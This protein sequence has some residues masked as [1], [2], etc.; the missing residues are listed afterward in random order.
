M[1]SYCSHSNLSHI[2]HHHQWIKRLVS[3]ETEQDCPVSQT[4]FDF[5]AHA[6]E[7]LAVTHKHR[8]ANAANQDVLP[9]AAHASSSRPARCWWGVWAGITLSSSQ[10][11]V[12]LSDHWLSIVPGLQSRQGLW[13]TY[14][15]S[16][17]CQTKHN[18]THG[19]TGSEEEK[20]SRPTPV[21]II[22]CYPS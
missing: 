8:S 17:V 12:H 15:Q 18:K 21:K 2:I 22:M 6:H 10:H 14:W 9:H 4:S 16:H 20:D 5:F 1:P 7:A 3:S 19:Y 13:I 11:A